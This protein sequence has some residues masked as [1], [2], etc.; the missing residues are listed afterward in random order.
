[1]LLLLYRKKHH[2][3]RR[4]TLEV[5]GRIEHHPLTWAPYL[6]QKHGLFDIIEM[7]HR[8]LEAMRESGT[9]QQ[10]V[11]ELIDLAAAATMAANRMTCAEGAR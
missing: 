4:T 6:G 8:E 9:H 7:E 3:V 5:E 10:V 1:M 2:D 11:K